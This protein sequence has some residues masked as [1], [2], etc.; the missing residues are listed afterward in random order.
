METRLHAGGNQGRMA[1]ETVRWWL[2][3][4]VKP[5]QLRE[6]TLRE[7]RGQTELESSVG[8]RG[9]AGRRREKS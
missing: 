2:L 1:C 7:K 3:G 6:M 9:G 8:E 4:D 5:A